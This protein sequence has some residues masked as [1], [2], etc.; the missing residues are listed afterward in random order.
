MLMP[1][2]AKTG[3]VNSRDP[4]T[5]GDGYLQASQGLKPGLPFRELVAVIYVTACCE[6][7]T[8][9]TSCILIFCRRIVFRMPM[10]TFQS[11]RR[12]QAVVNR[13]VHQVPA[14]GGGTSRRCSRPAGH[15]PAAT[16]CRQHAMKVEGK[17]QRAST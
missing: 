14:Y 8:P 4:N 12:K 3:I 13:C 6:E 9:S 7:G 10:G 5:L 16:Y 15:G 11:G 17:L 1:N 2:R